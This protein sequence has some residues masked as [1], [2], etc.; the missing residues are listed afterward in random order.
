MKASQDVIRQFTSNGWFCSKGAYVLV[1]GQYGS[2]GKGLLASVM[3]EAGA[4]LI[5]TVTT[6]AGPNSGHTAYSPVD[7]Q[8]I[9]T[10]QIPIAGVVLHQ[11]GHAPVVYMN[12]GSVINPDIF[13]TEAE[14]IAKSR[15]SVSP[16]AAVIDPEDLVTEAFGS[17]SQIA[18]T[19][20]GVG[21]ESPAR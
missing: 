6:N 1:D 18:S 13:L 20:K 16:F 21:S 17:P 15:I 5:S 14:L 12:A 7:S 19:A 4:G 8:K 10:Q 11:M 3:A 9:V 2:T